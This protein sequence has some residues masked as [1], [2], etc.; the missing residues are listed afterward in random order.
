MTTPQHNLYPSTNPETLETPDIRSSVV[1]ETAE[2]Y[3]EKME[4]HIHNPDLHELITSVAADRGMEIPDLT[5]PELDEE[6]FMAA[7]QLALDFRN[8]QGREAVV[9]T[10]LSPRTLDALEAVKLEFNMTVDTTPTDPEADVIFI[11]GGAGRTPHNRL[12]YFQKLEES[13]ALRGKTVVMIGSERPVNEAERGRAEA[14]YDGA[15]FE[16]A[17]TEFE[18]SR[19]TAGYDVGIAPEEWETI[20]GYDASIPEQYHFQHKYRVAV[21]EK[22]GVNFMV[23]SAPMMDE[24]RL[25]PDGNPRPRSNTR[26]GYHFVASMMRDYAEPGEAIKSVTVTDGIFTEFQGADASALAVHGVKN[27]TVGFTRKTAGLDEWPGGN[28]LYVQ[29]VLS[30]LRQTRVARD[31]L[32]LRAA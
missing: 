5:D 6:T 16:G 11:L 24:D 31:A 12:A 25:Y 26:D 3:R 32:E 21:A 20:E 14:A 30:A 2:L 1:E 13:G 22:D 10:G 19:M 7:A 29:E 27:E 18:L 15:S 23:V 9:D 28:N 8:G 17:T 4:R